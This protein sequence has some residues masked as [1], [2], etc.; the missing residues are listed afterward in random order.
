MWRSARQREYY[1]STPAKTALLSAVMDARRHLEVS[2]AFDISIPFVLEAAA[3][4]L[5]TP[6]VPMTKA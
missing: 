5:E 2:M 4:P 3:L 6:L 1:L